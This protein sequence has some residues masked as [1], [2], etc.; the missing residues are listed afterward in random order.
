[1]CNNITMKKIAI[2][3]GTFNPVHIEHVKMVERLIEELG[4]DKVIVVPTNIPPHKSTELLSNEDRLNMLNLCFGDNK[5]VEVS[6]F[7]INNGGKSYSYITV[8][9]FSKIYP[10]DIL[11]F[12]VGGDMLKDFKTW[13]NPQK[14]LDKATLVVFAR[15]DFEVDFEAEEEY[16]KNNYNSEFIRLN[17]NG[18][19]VSSTRIRIYSALGLPI[20]SM[21]SKEVEKYIVEKKLFSGKKEFEFVKNVLPKKRLIHTAEV[22]VLALK[23]VRELALDKD[24]VT[25]ACILHDCAKYVDYKSVDGFKLEKGVPEPVIHSF[26]GAYLAKNVL[27]VEDEEVLDAI[28]YHT[29]GKANMSTLG[30]LLFVADMIEPTRDYE[31]VEYLRKLYEEDFEKCFIECLKEEMVHLKNKTKD[32]YFE[33]INAYDYYVKKRED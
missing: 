17:Y 28:S 26:L 30:K 7:E 33:T 15:D 14:I 22:A 32:I 2:F 19:D 13:K 18:K 25:L 24:K 21:T 8:E 12:L 5:K 31:G 29:S 10:N 20:D 6:D 27:K 23:K 1:M 4:I 9:H 16:F 3:G 11:Y